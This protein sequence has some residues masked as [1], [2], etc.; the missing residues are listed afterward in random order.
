MF[1]AAGICTLLAA[2]LLLRG[3][4]PAVLHYPAYDSYDVSGTLPAET[5][6]L[7]PNSSAEPEGLLPVLLQEDPSVNEP[8]LSS[9]THP[10]HD[11]ETQLCSICGE[12]V[13]HCYSEMVCSCGRY[14]LPEEL[15]IDR[16]LFTPSAHAGHTE[17]VAYSIADHTGGSGAIYEKKMEIYVPY[18]YDPDEAYDVVFLLPGTGGKFTYW[19]S[20]DHPYRYPDGTVETVNLCTLFDNM[21]DNRI[22]RPFLAVS[23]TSYRNDAERSASDRYDILAA[24]LAQELP[25]EILPAIISRY[26]TYAAGTDRFSLKT[27]RPHFGFIGASAGSIIGTDAF[28]MRNSEIIGWFGLFSGCKKTP[29]EI[30][31][32]LSQDDLKELPI[33]GYYAAAGI[34]DFL[35]EGTYR[36]FLGLRDSGLINEANSAYTDIRSAEHEDRVWITGI[37]NCLQ[38]FFC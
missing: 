13:C 38:L 19:L 7:F 30:I 22:C 11:P 37:Y 20:E 27:A 16:H 5:P 35:R 23:L 12:K 25:E 1:I 3:F 21:I 36:T 9:C 32:V 4:D 26:S 28:L 18:G 24:Q 31:S 33:C 2:C 34:N 15:S 14:F 10:S 29:E 8:S 17:T 6:E